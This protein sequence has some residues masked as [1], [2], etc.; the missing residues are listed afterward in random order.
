MYKTFRSPPGS[1]AAP[2]TVIVNTSERVTP[3][4]KCKL[5]DKIKDTDTDNHEEI[6]RTGLEAKKH[7]AKDKPVVN[8]DALLLVL[9]DIDTDEDTD[10]TEDSEDEVAAAQHPYGITGSEPTSL[11]DDDDNDDSDVELSDDQAP[12]A[13]R[14][15]INKELIEYEKFTPHKTDP[16]KI[17]VVFRMKM[18]DGNGWYVQNDVIPEVREAAQ[19]EKYEEGDCIFPLSLEGSKVQRKYKEQ[20]DSSEPR[21]VKSAGNCWV[22]TYEGKTDVFTPKIVH[23]RFNARTHVY[24]QVYF[25]KPKL[26]NIDPNDKQWLYAYN[27]WLD[28]IMRRSDADYVQNKLREHWKQEEICAMYTA[29]NA[30]FHTN[31]IDAYAH[32]SNQDLQDIMNQVNAAGHRNRG[33][34]ALRGQMNSAHGRKNPSMAYLRDNLPPLK[35]YM[36]AGGI[37][38]QDERFPKQFI[39]E[40]EFPKRDPQDVW[41]LPSDRTLWRHRGKKIRYRS[42]GTQTGDDSDAMKVDTEVNTDGIAKVKSTLPAITKKRKRPASPSASGKKIRPKT[43]VSRSKERVGA[44]GGNSDQGSAE[45]SEAD[46]PNYHP[47]PQPKKQRKQE[48]EEDDDDDDDEYAHRAFEGVEFDEGEDDEIAGT[49]SDTD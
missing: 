35:D 36:E 13:D 32:M 41:R 8:G 49:L 18:P 21:W 23:R 28:Q 43:P 29:F 19:M 33:L 10:V 16:T 22:R 26:N 6:T 45:A 14:D 48:V 15:L 5:G 27:K 47:R 11:L 4:P 39:P 2:R 40:E 9:A 34:E 30:F 37:I 17:N 24:E 31:G 25:S 44:S 3:K 20:H 1:P 7:V 38:A 42:V 12:Y 46:D